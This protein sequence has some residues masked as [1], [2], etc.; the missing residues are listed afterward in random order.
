MSFPSHSTLFISTL[1]F[2]STLT[3][4][5][6][7]GRYP[8]NQHAMGKRR[9]V[10]KAAT[11]AVF[12]PLAYADG[13]ISD[14]T[15]GSAQAKAEA[16]CVTPFDGL[17]LADVS[18]DDL[19]NLATFREDAENA[20]T[21][22]FNPAIDAATGAE[23]TALKNGKIANKVLKLTCFDQVLKI[24][25][26]QG[27]SNSA[28]ITDEQTKLATNIA[29][30]K[31]VAGQ[32]QKGVT[33]GSA[34]STPVDIAQSS[35]TTTSPTVAGSSSSGS[36]GTASS[37][38]GSQVFAPLSFADGQISDGIAGNAQARA[39]AVCVDPF[40]NTSL[41]DVSAEDLDN[42]QTFREAAETAETDLF[43]PAIDAASGAAKTALSN[44]KIANKVLK[45][46][47]EVQALKIK[48]AQ[49]QDV[50][51]DI[52]AEQSK[53]DKNISTDKAAAGQPQQV[54]A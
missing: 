18:S 27:A 48:G 19:N 2:L 26:A 31:A 35:T 47:C 1:L 36:S 40:S 32:P 17:D 15:A 16:V 20:E 50:G 54:A 13:Q 34:E 22:L 11:I 10:E 7:A 8:T 49:G 12:P 29:L 38:S 23:A 51:S 46:T 9:L 28:K 42:L 14:G 3:S 37:S 30:D 24:Q 25:A 21:E 52:A 44:G 4:S 6:T 39:Q 41:A 5:V 43:N 33:G 45:L 53:L